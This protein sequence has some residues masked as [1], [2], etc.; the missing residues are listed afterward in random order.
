M[1]AI[2]VRRKADGLY[3]CGHGNKE[4]NEKGKIWKAVNHAK[5]ALRQLAPYFIQDDLGRTHY[6]KSPYYEEWY[7]NWLKQFELEVSE[8]VPT[9]AEIIP[10]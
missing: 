2:R 6:S 7:S 1:K 5:C 3:Y 9:K 4:F 10:C 8:L